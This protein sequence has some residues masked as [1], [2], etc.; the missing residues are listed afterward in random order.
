MINW[1][2]V[3][4]QLRVC[5][6]AQTGVR[7]E[8][9]LESAFTMQIHLRILQFKRSMTLFVQLR[10]QCSKGKSQTTHVRLWISQL[11]HARPWPVPFA[12]NM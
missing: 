2:S 3:V 5:V 8:L 12:L 10:V 1:L 4:V 9:Q 7:A 11:L 6:M